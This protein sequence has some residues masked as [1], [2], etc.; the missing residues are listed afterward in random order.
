MR[1]TL[2]LGRSRTLSGRFAE[3]RETFEAA[4]ALA[5]ELGDGEALARAGLGMSLVAVA[6][7]VDEPLLELLEEALELIEPGDSVLAGRAP[8]R[9]RRRG[10]C[11]AIPTGRPRSSPPRRSRWRS[12][13]ATTTRSQSR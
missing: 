5:R 4:A 13:S 9:A 1:L 3:A 11:G 7:T 2:E 6:A 12:G 10:C 8:E